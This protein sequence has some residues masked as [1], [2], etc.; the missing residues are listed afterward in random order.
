MLLLILWTVHTPIH[1]NNNCQRQ[2]AIDTYIVPTYTVKKLGI[3][4]PST[5]VNRDALHQSNP[6][7]QQRRITFGRLHLHLHTTFT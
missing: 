3:E 2:R 4:A 7:R 1:T 5:R 6:I